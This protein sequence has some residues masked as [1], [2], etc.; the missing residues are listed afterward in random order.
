VGLP[1]GFARG[2]GENRAHAG[3]IALQGMGLMELGAHSEE[4][5]WG[6]C[7]AV[8]CAEFGH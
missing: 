5:K 4:A 3:G 2:G 7:V 1:A 8:S 6:E